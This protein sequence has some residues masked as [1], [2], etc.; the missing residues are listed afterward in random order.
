MSSN[1]DFLNNFKNTHVTVIGDI[2]LDRFVYGTVDRISP[3]SPVP[4]LNIKRETSMLGGAGNTLSNLHALGCQTSAI[5]TI[6]D[7]PQGETIKDLLTSLSC[8]T[9]TLLIR[10]DIP[11]TQKTRFLSG[12]Q[13]LLRTDSERIQA[14]NEAETQTLKSYIDKIIQKT[15]AI[16]LSD[17]GKGLLGDDIIRYAIDQAKSR[18]IPVIVDPKGTDFRKYSGATA[19]TPNKKEL[20]E[21]TASGAVDTDESVVITAQ[22]LLTQAN[23]EA[24]IAT[25]AADGISVI[26]NQGEATHIKASRHIEVFDVSGAGDTVIATIA[27]CLCAGASLEDAAR[28]ANIAGSIVVSKVGT[29]PIRFKELHAAILE[30]DSL[31]LNLDIAETQAPATTLKEGREHIQRW[32]ARGLKIGF[33]NGCFDILHM[34][35][36]TY[37][38]EAKDQCD[39]LIVGLNHDVSVSILKGPSRPIHDEASRAAVLKALASVDMVILFGATE[40]DG[41]NTACDLLEELQPDIYFKGGDYKVEDIPEAPTVFKHGG[42]VKVLSVKEGYSTTAA[43]E[44]AQNKAA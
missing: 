31:H 20:S 5:S 19:I 10:Q 7:D 4:V 38:Q 3:E 44:K 1:F 28:T 24:V 33:T 35:H 15:N 9:D 26:R 36:V 13:Q 16:I 40:H 32:K 30:N 41:D 39:R 8:P 25:R 22:S 21:A 23:I 2:M 42:D 11:T 6:G 14:L 18:N 37:L 12:H 34:G 29:A 27:A 17:Y 43:I